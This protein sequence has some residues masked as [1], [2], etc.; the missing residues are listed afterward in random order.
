M[1]NKL[2]AYAHMG[3]DLAFMVASARSLARKAAVLVGCMLAVGKHSILNRIEAQGVGHH[4]IDS[5]AGYPTT[6]E[7]SPNYSP[8]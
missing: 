8:I 3:V 6:R 4:N 1:G 7:D 5:W 2:G